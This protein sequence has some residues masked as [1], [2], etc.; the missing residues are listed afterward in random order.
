MERQTA[1][2]TDLITNT[3]I[4]FSAAISLRDRT[5][6]V[7]MRVRVPAGCVTAS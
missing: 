7:A 1:H 5:A 4:V 2:Q 3:R 6:A